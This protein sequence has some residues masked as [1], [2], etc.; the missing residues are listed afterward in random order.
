MQ[1]VK[2]NENESFKESVFKINNIRI[3]IYNSYKL[4]TLTLSWKKIIG[5]KT[6]T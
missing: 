4:T 1:L 5:E 3:I 6:F 2:I